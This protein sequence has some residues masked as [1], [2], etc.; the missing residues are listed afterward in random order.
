MTKTIQKLLLFD[1]DGTLL[2]AGGIGREAKARAMQL[3]FGTDAGVRTF[4]FGGKTDFQIMLE[5]MGDQYSRDDIA[6]RMDDFQVI[7][8]EQM[9]A[10]VADYPGTPL[11]GAMDLVNALRARP[12]VLLGIVSGNT[13][14]TAPIKLQAAGYDPLWFPVG[15]YGNES[16]DRND[17]PK[18]ALQ[19]AIE[20]AKHDIAANDV[21]V[22]GD[23]VADVLCARAL[24]AMAVTVFTGFEEREKLIAAQPDVMLEDLTRFWQHI[25]F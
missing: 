6:A 3:M 24:G 16:P 10:L 8:A 15:A 12:D 4:P 2:N 19:R 23:T 17:L 21:I 18:F 20:H 11:P 5:L 7:F 22:I 13:S 1:I 25:A 14:K 9:Q